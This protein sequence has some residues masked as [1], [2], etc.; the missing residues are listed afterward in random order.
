[1]L[2][3]LAKK[4][5]ILWLYKWLFA[6]V[7]I[8][9]QSDVLLE[10][11]KDSTITNMAWLDGTYWTTS[12]RRW[13]IILWFFRFVSWRTWDADRHDCDDFADSLAVYVKT[14]TG[15][16]AVGTVIGDKTR[17]PE[18]VTMDAY[19]KSITTDRHAWNVIVASDGEL[20]VEP[21][22]MRVLGEDSGYKPAEVR[23]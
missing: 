12:T 2:F 15:L 11:V 16:T 7:E 17:A 1:M 22:S 3:Y 19:G 23:M 21:Q 18:D 20:F 10:W 5:R 4:L 9:K 8:S 6:P 13:R 14:I